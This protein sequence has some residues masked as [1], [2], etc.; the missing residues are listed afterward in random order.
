M[1]RHQHQ[2]LIAVAVLCRVA[3]YGRHRG[4]HML[5]I[6]LAYRIG[7]CVVD[8][9]PNRQPIYYYPICYNFGSGKKLS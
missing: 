3:N 7:S 5:P 4:L 6:Y 1:V 8:T 2:Q 9:A